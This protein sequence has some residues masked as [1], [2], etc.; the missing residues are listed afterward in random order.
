[1]KALVKSMWLDSTSADL[2]SYTPENP[3]CFGLWIEFRVGIVDKDGADDFRLWVCTPDWLANECNKG[4]GVWG[5]HT[6]VV[7]EY[8]LEKIK[9]EINSFVE[10]FEGD[11]W[12]SIAQNLVKFAAWEYEGMSL[13]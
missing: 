13:S 11:N 4:I 7:S 3:H 5:R 2:S 6:L 9:S 8:D 1:M 12:V 10:K